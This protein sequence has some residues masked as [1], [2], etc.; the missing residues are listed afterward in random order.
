MMNIM[1]ILAL[2][3]FASS[4]VMAATPQCSS[5]ALTQAEKLLSFHVNGDDRARI[6]PQTK[7][8][9]SIANPANK[10]QKFIVLEVMGYVYKGQYRMR[11]IYYP[12]G[13]ECVLMGQEIL[14]LS[15]L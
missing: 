14:E 10:D 9:P 11:L 5:F 2:F 8:L 13:K 3:L 6:E 7:Q 1:K 15:N 12:L 4:N